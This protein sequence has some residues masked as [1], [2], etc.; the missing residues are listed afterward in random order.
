L[1]WSTLPDVEAISKGEFEVP[2]F[3]KK[4]KVDDQVRKAGFKY[5][6][7]VSHHFIFKIFFALWLLNQNKM[8]LLDGHF[9]LTQRRKHFTW[10][11]SMTWESSFG[12]F[13]ATGK[14]WK[15][16]LSSL[17]T[18]FFSFNDVANAYK[19]NGKEYS[20]TQVPSEVFST[21]FEGAKE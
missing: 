6:T 13:T 9:L 20:I 1:F 11:T 8:A 5:Y 16:S 12:S 7:F 18:E 10:Q 2:H 14:S 19:V 21:F 15:R 4:A 3:T 17:A